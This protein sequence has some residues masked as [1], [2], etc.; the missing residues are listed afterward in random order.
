VDHAREA[1]YQC[2]R[3]NALAATLHAT[4]AIVLDLRARLATAEREAKEARA[5][6]RQTEAAA[7]AHVATIARLQEQ[8]AAAHRAA[9][10]IAHAE[11]TPGVAA[12]GAEWSAEYDAIESARERAGTDDPPPR[13]ASRSVRYEAVMRRSDEIN[14]GT[15]D[16]PPTRPSERTATRTT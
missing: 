3:A 7:G 15:D 11:Q 2:D 5:Q 1:V 9:H 6:L 8:I 4:E 14:A 10:A 12:V 16:P 13:I